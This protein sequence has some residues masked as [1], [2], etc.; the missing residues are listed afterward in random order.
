MVL[1]ILHLLTIPDTYSA[2]GWTVSNVAMAIVFSIIAGL[3]FAVFAMPAMISSVL[4]GLYEGDVDAMRL[5]FHPACRLY[6][7]QG[8]VLRELG[9]ED[10]YRTVTQRPGPASLKEPRA[11]RI[12]SLS[13][14]EAGSASATLHTTRAL[15]IYTDPLS[16][17][18]LDGHWQIVSKT[19][20][21]TE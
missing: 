20:S 15:R 17:L 3:A 9:M 2:I 21:W 16:L 10:Y 4:D 5:V 13:V 12:L 8:G 1:A 7:G 14:S 19:Y 18:Y 6:S 11:D